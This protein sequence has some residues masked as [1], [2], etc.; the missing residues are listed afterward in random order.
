MSAVAGP[1]PPSPVAW[2]EE[3]ASRW[4]RF[5]GRIESFN[6]S[7]SPLP[8]ADSPRRVTTVA[9]TVRSLAASLRAE[10]MRRG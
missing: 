6:Q 9:S 1:Q 3:L 5:A 4:E 7:S 8:S 2:A 10:A